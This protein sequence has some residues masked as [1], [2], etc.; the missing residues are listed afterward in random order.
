MNTSSLT[1]YAVHVIWAGC[2][3]RTAALAPVRDAAQEAL[4]KHLERQADPDGVLDPAKRAARVKM[5]KSEHYATLA[6]R[7]AEV[8]RAKGRGAEV[9]P[10]AGVDA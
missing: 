9:R 3:D 1:T 6:R 5:A 8:R 7:S 10:G 2:E 4:N